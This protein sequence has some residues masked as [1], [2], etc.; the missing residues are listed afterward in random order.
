MIE[1][2]PATKVKAE[3]AVPG[4][5]SITQRALI[6]AALADGES[7]LLGPLESED[8]RYTAAAL[9]QMGVTV[10]KGKENWTVIGNGGR[11][12]TPAKEIFLGNNGTATRFL[13][14]V[15]AL[16]AGTFR[17]SGDARMA[18]RPILPLMQALQGWGVDIASINNNGCPPLVIQA[19]G[20]SGGKT[21]LPAGKSSQY[22]S[23]LLLVGPYA[24]Q[25]AELDVQGEILS[26]PY[27]IMTLAVM[28]S[29][30]I[31]VEANEALNSYSIPRGIYRA[32]KY[33]IEGDASNASYFY[34]AAAITG[35]EV[36]VPNV[37]V[38]S[39]QGDAAFVALLARMGCQVNKTGEGLTVS[40]PEELRGITI[41]MADMPDVVPTLAV[42]ASQ[43]KGRTVIKN[44]AHLRIKECDRL[45]VMAVELAK[46]GARVE[47]LEDTLIIEGNAPDTPMHGAEINTYN[48]HRIAMSFAVA[49]LAVPG[50]KI[51][52]E[53]CVAKSFP[54][55]WERFA[56]LYG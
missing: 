15:A 53:E 52:G 13:A 34:A 30:G 55:F 14:S 43:A 7:V 47:E 33:A 6:A 9:A 35:G 25:E 28:E 4:S 49:G 27:V 38:P 11:I 32:R 40:G 12:E 21:I 23:S 18:E 45:H 17:I 24:R 2:R 37:P 41:D 31:R 26:L 46:L 48:D 39:L 51:L 42:V 5:K 3:V 22:L 20:L 56:L 50:V 16:G 44:I 1:I 8:T 19:N 54:D 29:F 36:T 10:E